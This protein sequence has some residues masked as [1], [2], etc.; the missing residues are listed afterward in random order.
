MIS[1]TKE[2]NIKN[3]VC[4]EYAPTL[5]ALSFRE[6]YSILRKRSDTPTLLS[7]LFNV[8]YKYYNT[9]NKEMQ[10]TCKTKCTIIYKQ[11]PRFKKPQRGKTNM[12][13]MPSDLSVSELKKSW[14]SET[15]PARF[16]G[17]DDTM[18]LIFVARRKGNK[19]HLVR[20]ARTVSDPFSTVFRGRLRQTK[21]GSEIVGIFTKRIIDYVFCIL[22]V[23]LLLYVQ[24]TVIQKGNDPYTVNILLVSSVVGSL[25]ALYPFRKT[26]RRYTDFMTDV[27]K[28]EVKLFLSRREKKELDSMGD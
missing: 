22:L 12:T 5:W 23:A 4:A 7:K 16:A 13:K 3:A 18:D 6:K 15:S 27:T 14:D 2:K 24:T 26:K 1:G 9:Q 10:L 19:V 17:C 20:K 25:L 21:N 28:K 11:E 8:A